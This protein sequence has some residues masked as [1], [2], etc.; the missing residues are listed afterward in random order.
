MRT[1]DIAKQFE[2][3]TQTVRNWLNEFS[4]YFDP[5]E[6]RQANIGQDGFIVLATIAQLSKAGK[7][8]ADIHEQ[9]KSG[10][11]ADELEAYTQPIDLIPLQVAADNSRVYAELE[12]IKA[13]R[14]KLLELLEKSDREKGDLQSKV[15]ELQKEIRELTDRAARAEGRLEEKDRRRRWF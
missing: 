5:K 15:D 7:G 2:V 13:E 4:E 1:G 10:Y 3:T 14:D 8:Y 12:I 6:A 9:L 11:R